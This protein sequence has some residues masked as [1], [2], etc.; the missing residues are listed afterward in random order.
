MRFP[1][2]F[3][4]PVVGLKSLDKLETPCRLLLQERYSRMV[5]RMIEG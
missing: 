3:V 4:S 2:D 1:D 5:P